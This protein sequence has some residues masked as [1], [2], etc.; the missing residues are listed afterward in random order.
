M[1]WPMEHSDQIKPILRTELR[2]RWTTRTL[3][4]GM[5][6]I[7]TILWIGAIPLRFAD[8]TVA[9]IEPPCEAARL[10]PQG[11]SV[12]RQLG[13]SSAAY[14]AYTITAEVLVVVLFLTIGALI[15]R[16]QTENRFAV[17][18]AFMLLLFGIGL[19]EI[20]QVLEPASPAFRTALRLLNSLGF[21]SFFVAWYLFPD[22]R[23]Y[24]G[25]AKYLAGLWI[26]F[27]IPWTFPDLVPL[28][29]WLSIPITLGL[30]A[31]CLWAQVYRY[32]RRSTPAQR[33][34][35]KW[36]LF[37]LIVMVF[38]FTAYGVLPIFVPTLVEPGVRE[39]LFFGLGRTLV[40]ICMVILPLTLGIAMWRYRLWEIDLIVNR[41]FIYATL[42]GLMIGIYALIAGSLGLLFQ[43]QG[44]WFVSLVAAG[45]VAVLFQPLRVWIQRGTNRMLFGERDDPIAVLTRLARMLEAAAVPGEVLS[46][47]EA[48]IAQALRIP[49]AAINLLEEGEISRKVASGNPEKDTYEFPLV[50]Q[51]EMLGNLIVA[52]REPGEA[53][54]P[55]DQNL[56]ENIAR[57][58]GPAIY[59]LKLTADLQR[60]RER[61]VV[62]REEERRRIRRDLHDGLGPLLASQSLLLESLEKLIHHDTDQ[63]WQ[64]IN[65]LKLQTQT[66]LSDVRQLIYNLRPPSLDDLGLVGA[67]KEEINRHRSGDLHI[68][69]H[70]EDLPPLPAAVEVAIFRI[71]QE[72]VTNVVRHASAVSC[73]VH[74]RVEDS[75]DKARFL[76]EV[77]DDGCGLQEGHPVGVGLESMRE[78]AAELGG[79]CWVETVIGKG[80]TVRAWI[81]LVEEG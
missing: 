51:N 70:S 2:L 8:L 54:S 74:L 25:W 47:I 24:P 15:M 80:T 76:V 59:A 44:N 23:F 37:G 3:W 56:L 1:W 34:Q 20:L 46:K 35:T 72:A 64:V 6:L 26:V 42:T 55:A 75:S 77:K 81:P 16:R 36:V 73:E 57:Q 29:M 43:A 50:Y 66:A 33:Q 27:E 9:C 78:R 30:I 7:L 62:G 14:A 79:E 53:L 69:I 45:G 40:S 38:A 31:S 19:S 65:E 52:S 5:A 63:A 17:F 22:G 60:S 39:V 61:L 67:L 32:R 18:A 41:T 68:S 58:A 21:V 49:Y 28:P 10:S 11:H 13:L 48:T 71:V 12:L 4:F